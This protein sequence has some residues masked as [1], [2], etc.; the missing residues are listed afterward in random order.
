MT[1]IKHRDEFMLPDRGIYALSHSVGC[2]PA[3]TRAAFEAEFTRPWATAGGEAWP[4]W[5]RAIDRFRA[6][7]A[8]LLGGAA[9]DFAP[10][11]N[12]SSGL[13]KLLA[14][15][16]KTVGRDTWVTHEGSFP[17]IG[18]VLER[19]SGSKCRLLVGPPGDLALW[20]DALSERVSA[21][22]ITHVHSNTGTIEPVR[23]ITTR[24]RELGILSVVDVAQSAGIMP[25]SLDALGA[26]VVVGSCVKWLCGG[27]GAGFLWIRPGVLP[28]LR[29]TDVGWFSH[30]DPFEMDIRH[31]EY[32]PDARRFWGGTPSVLPYVAAAHGIATLQRIGMDAI[33]THNRR[34]A[35]LFLEQL[36]EH[37]AEQLQLESIGGTVCVPLGDAV[38][39]VA[40]ALQ[41][42]GHFFDLRGDRLR[43]SFHCY[44]S[45]DEA[46]LLGR[47]CSGA[48]GNRLGRRS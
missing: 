25:I 47:L 12:V 39:A 31:F 19:A 26:D 48:L 22:V 42:G 23:G 3:A 40:S 43:V 14:A 20:D 21:A 29:P 28:T 6:A 11:T 15:M 45:E 13:S 18:F 37:Y 33:R 27:P 41:A 9:A 17:S 34:L 5:L 16:G 38:A 35:R 10:Q 8:V 2:I 4:V 1:T 46:E 30:S 44:N 24:C 36:P 7:L 32:A